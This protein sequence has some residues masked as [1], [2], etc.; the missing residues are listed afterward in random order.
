MKIKLIEGGQCPKRMTPKAV[1]Y[2]V[3]AR[4]IQAG[5]GKATIHLGFAI[6]MD[7]LKVDE[8][9]LFGALLLPRSGWGTKYNFR[10]KNTTGVIDPDYRGEVVMEAYYDKEPPLEVG[11]RV[12][13]MLIVPVYAG[14][15]FI[16]DELSTTERGEGG[17]GHT[18]D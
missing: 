12:G 6:D 9:L 13:Q 11:A 17:F 15:L 16:F 2:D 18:G 5:H 10:L 3:Y 14:E 8:P 7:V 4:A 1:G